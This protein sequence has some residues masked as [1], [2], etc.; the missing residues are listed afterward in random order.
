[1]SCATVVVAFVMAYGCDATTRP[2][3][4]PAKSSEIQQ[5][6]ARPRLAPA[7]T[8][9]NPTPE[10]TRAST[11]A[12]STP[13]PPVTPDVPTSTTASQAAYVQVSTGENHVCALRSDGV[14]ECWGANDHGQL[15]PPQ[16]VKFRQVASGWHF[17]CGIDEL[18]EIACWGRDNYEQSSPPSG[19]F[20][21]LRV[22]WDHACANGPGGAACW[23]RAA[24]DRTTVPAG[25]TFTAIG[26]GAEHSCG[27]TSDGDLA[28]WGKNDDGRARA[29]KGPFRALAVGLV[30]T[31]ALRLD[32]EV[33]C[34]GGN[35][36]GRSI[37][38]N[39]VF[40]QISAGADLTCGTLVTGHVECW[41]FTPDELPPQTFGPPGAYWSVSVGWKETCAI[42]DAGHI[43][44]WGTEKAPRPERFDRLVIATSFPDIS[45]SEPIEIF[46]W[47]TGGLVIADKQGTVS[48]LSPTA[49]IRPMLDLTDVVDSDGIENGML[50]ATVDPQFETSGY[51]Y[52]YYTMRDTSSDTQ[53]FARL[54]RF[55][56]TNGVA[57]RDQELVILDISRDTDSK[58][59][60]G[61]AI[62]FGPDGMLY[63]GIGDGHCFECPQRLDSLH[64]KIIRIDVR[65]ATSDSPYLIPPD[66]PMIDEPGARPEIWAYGLRNP[67][68]M[69]FDQQSGQLWVG[70][71][72]EK[73]E[74]EISIAT[75]GS[76]LGWPY[77]EGFGCFVAPPM[78][79]ENY[80]IED[81][82]PCREHP[83]LKMPLISYTRLNDCA[84]VGGLVYRGDAIPW[85]QGVYLFGDF[86]SGRLWAL[87]GDAESEWRLVEIA[88]LDELLTSFGVDAHGEVLM[89]SLGGSV[90]RFVDAGSGYA[91]T[92]T[93]RVQ[94]TIVRLALEARATMLSRTRDP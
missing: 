92:V 73:Q 55:P 14:I 70:D 21:D 9:P 60:W 23:G 59:H 74:E 81:A 11:A 25:V 4:A 43:A 35:D 80:G 57:R 91:P 44:C 8:S 58:Y 90:F 29:R 68:R 54:S 32:G 13:I 49:D 2:P 93:H 78:A 72:G 16:G 94:P 38:P 7:V 34:Q 83:D 53:L 20:T 85:L 42:S 19:Q 52:V 31:C 40:D 41:D 47:P 10:Q 61:G 50:S 26:A 89:L 36:R 63:L 46:S 18:G 66:N 3:P 5:P 39:T 12:Q 76:N 48:L 27:L 65:E 71:V 77:L 56:V 64:G 1:M 45:L 17:T 79:K 69:S 15:D 24:N 28:C 51:L 37:P 30:H 86:C 6:A 33:L 22:G 75:A 67:W 87:G 62:R 84:V 82:H 88:D